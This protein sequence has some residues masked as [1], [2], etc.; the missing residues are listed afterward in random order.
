MEGRNE[1]S[2]GPVVRIAQLDIDP[3][4]REAFISAVKVEMEES[5]RVEPGVLAIYAAAEKEAPFRLRFFEIYDSEAAYRAHL[6]SPHFRT[7]RTTTDPMVRSRT[8]TETV[9]V[10]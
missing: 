10:Q 8:L 3:A 6:Q 2:D 9:T 5:V 7:F 1:V 4:Q